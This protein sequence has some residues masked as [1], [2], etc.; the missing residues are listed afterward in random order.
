MG[1]TSGALDTTVIVALLDAA[2]RRLE[3]EWLLVGGALASIWFSPDRTTEDVDLI[4][5]SGTNEERLALMELAREV[6][7]PVEAVNSAADYFVRKTAGWRDQLDVLR[8]TERLT[9][10]R[11]TPTLFLLLKLGR[12]TEQDL[13]DCL[14]LL[15]FADRE[16]LSVDRDRVLAALERLE[17]V[18]DEPLRARRGSLR[19]RISR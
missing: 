3:G 11:P 16:G 9:V 18:E 7:L 14:Q 4:G 15:D 17:D 2:E 13:D 5:L 10:Y 12:L 19:A 8:K 1:V 6:G